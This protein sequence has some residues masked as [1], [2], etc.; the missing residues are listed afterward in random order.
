[1]EPT[2]DRP[3]P[4]SAEL[5]A[6][7]LRLRNEFEGRFLEANLD[8][9]IGR[10]RSLISRGIGLEVDG[11]WWSFHAARWSFFRRHWVLLA[12]IPEV[13][14]AVRDYLEGQLKERG[15]SVHQ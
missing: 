8:L 2:P 5:Q 3:V 9:A 15:K 4:T 10:V 14:R 12:D 7:A 6:L 11:E 1:M 13:E